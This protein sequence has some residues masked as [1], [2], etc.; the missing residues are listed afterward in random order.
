MMAEEITGS[1]TPEIRQNLLNHIILPRN[2]PQTKP[3]LFIEL[4][5]VNHVVE[6]IEHLAKWLPVKTVE[7]LMRFN[8]VHL[9]STPDPDVVSKQINS[10]RAGDTFAMFVRRQN[11]TFMVHMLP[12]EDNDN[13]ESHRIVVSTFPGNVHPSKVYEADSDIEVFV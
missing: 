13:K 8:K 9:Q 10:L 6:S 2:L 1:D 5:L 3:Q 11:T 4:K 7:F 12:N